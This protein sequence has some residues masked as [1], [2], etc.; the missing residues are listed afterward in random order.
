M[1]VNNP[2]ALFFAAAIP[3]IIALYLLR[4]RRKKLVVS[5][6]FFWTEMVQDLQANVPF[7]KLRW[8]ILL[9]LQILI[10]IAIIAALIDPA[11]KAALNEGQRTIFVIDT[12]ASMAAREGASTRFDHALA[13][14]RAYCRNLA[15]REQV[16]IIEAGEHARIALDFTDRIN[17]IERTL[18]SLSTWDTRSDMATAYALAVSKASEVDSPMIIIVSDFSGVDVGLFDDPEFP[19]SFLT[20]GSGARNVAITDFSITGVAE[21]ENVLSFDAFLTA[22]NFM[23][24]PVECDVEFLSEGELIDVRSIEIDPGSRMAK[25]Y[26][27]I[28]YPGGVIE[29][30]LDIRDDLELDNMAYAIPPAA[31]A[32]EVLIAGDDPFLLLSLAG[33]PGIRLYQIEM[34]EFVPGAGYD[35]IFFPGWAP[36]DLP[37]GNY[38]FFNPPDRDYL[39]CTVSSTVEAPQ[40]TDWDDGHP[41]LRFVNPGSFDVFA[42]TSIEPRPGAVTLID[43]DSTPLMVYGERNYLRALVFPFDLTSTD[44]I[45]RPTFP[46]L[47]YNVVSFFRSHTEGE[48]S[49]LRTQGVEAVRV[50]ALGEKI[51]LHGPRDIEL[52]FPI[53]AGHAFVDVNVAGVYEMEIE[54]AP[55][56]EHQLLVANFFDEAESD[57]SSVR[58]PDELLASEDITR[59]HVEGEKRVWKW[60]SVFALAVLCGEWFFYHR[61]GF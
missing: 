33:M 39:P 59:F 15:G 12:S 21:S 11:I 32:M 38:V 7:Q 3:V 44:L 57:V 53:D 9:L 40:V 49:G 18:D 19:L 45:T 54:G 50:D 22:R 24:Q 13:D 26:R 41:M 2:I 10:A 6:T 61:K 16:M 4:L 58:A 28:P 51:R 17:A 43:A 30:R 31:D 37:A 42:A 55:E 35:L 20:A 5:S 34:S 23:D 36:D 8:N 52:E 48:A 14:I 56:E 27:D 25:V 60:L 46:I 47:M 1:I 29:L